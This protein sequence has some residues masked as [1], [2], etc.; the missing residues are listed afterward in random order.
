MESLKI[1]VLAHTSRWLTLLVPAQLSCG[2][3]ALKAMLASKVL[4]GIEAEQGLKDNFLSAVRELLFNGIEHGGKLDPE[5]RIRIDL[6][7]S[8]RAISCFVRDP[9]AG[10][11]MREMRH[12]AINNPPED[13]VLHAQVREDNGLRPG[14][15][16]IL[17][18]S[19][20]VDELIYNE[21]GNEALIVKYLHSNK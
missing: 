8:N 2:D 7:H 3:E 10:F 16:G 13:A 1:E 4:H 9:G 12:A 17:L 21:H 15:Y 6:L 5:V 11:D 19:S 18:A 14:G 20:F